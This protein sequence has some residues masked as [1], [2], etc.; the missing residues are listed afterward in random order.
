M[1][2]RFAAGGYLACRRYV[3]GC[4]IIAEDKQWMGDEVAETV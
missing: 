1:P 3:V 2:A 4:H